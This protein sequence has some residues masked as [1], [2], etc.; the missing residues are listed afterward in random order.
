MLLGYSSHSVAY[1]RIEVQHS[2]QDHTPEERNHSDCVT[3][4]PVY[5][6]LLLYVAEFCFLLFPLCLDPLDAEVWVGSGPLSCGMQ[7][8][9][10]H[11]P[12]FQL[13]Y[14]QL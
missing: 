10:N 13:L 6:I 5:H 12:S 14:S 11:N 9:T 1:L 2:L 4:Q 7:N 8:T 3:T